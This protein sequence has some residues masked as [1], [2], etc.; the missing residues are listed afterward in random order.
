MSDRLFVLGAGAYQVPV[1]RR[2]RDLG[3]HVV[4][5][6]YLPDNPGHRL[7]SASEIV[8]TV[9]LDAILDVA[10]RHGV[11]G[12]LTYGS[13]VSVPAV[14]YV[15]ERLGLPG[16]PYETAALLQ[17]KDRIRELQRQIGLPHPRFVHAIGGGD[18]AARAA[19]EALPFPALVKPADASGSKGQSVAQRTGDLP[20]AFA[21][22]QPF[23]RCGVVV[24]EEILPDDT[25]ELVFE[26][27]IQDGRLAF[28]HY[29][30]NWFCDESHPRVPVG[31]IFP[32]AFGPA[33]IAEIDRQIQAL[34]TA[35]GVRTGCMNFDAL[36]S[37]GEVVI[38]DLGL[39]S[40]GNFVSDVVALSTGVDLT[41][42]AI[43][44]ALGRTVAVPALHVSDARCLVTYILHAH[45]TGRYAGATID[46]AVRPQLLETRMFVEAGAGVRP[47]TRGDAGLGVMFFD[48]PSPED[49]RA[50][51]A[52]VPHFC[53]VTLEPAAT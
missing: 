4:V 10:R 6:D 18:L 53:E 12:V 9:D 42:A 8:S 44:A 24:A 48:A 28:G 27:F 7:A 45:A 11:D 38:V 34:V 32:G 23:S 17:R 30:H 1:I 19:R 29:G 33:V 41:A 35:A 20:A 3:C 26:A 25:T 40:G 15:S 52:R 47:Y 14:A 51:V 31:E 16:N 2:A 36:L 49:A 13:D 21:L 46:P 5:A 50:L 37:R 43:D 22:A 39:R